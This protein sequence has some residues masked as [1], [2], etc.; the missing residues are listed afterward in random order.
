MLVECENCG[1]LVKKSPSHVKTLKHIFCGKKCRT[2]YRFLNKKNSKFFENINTEEKAYWLGF[3][4][5]DGWMCNRDP[6]FGVGL[7]SVDKIHLMKFA[8]L[9]DAKIIENTR[10]VHGKIYYRVQ[11]QV[12]NPFLYEQLLSKGV[13]PNKSLI[14]RLDVF[15][16][17]PKYLSSHFVRGWFDGDGSIY[18]NKVKCANTF[19]ICGT[20]GNLRKIQS[21]IL[22][23]VENLRVTKIK[24][25]KG[26]FALE[27]GGSHQAIAI[28]NW[29]YNDATVFLSRKKEKFNKVVR[30][31]GK[32]TSDYRGVHWN[33]ENEKWI[34]QITYNKK[35]HYLGSF[36][37]EEM[38][39]LAYT[40]ALINV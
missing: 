3:I 35:V 31:I 2:E 13:V 16:Y 25:T 20:K 11:I 10:V 32:K 26:I 19:S 33:K 22:N 18:I 21:M 9:F 29:L 1:E 8:R 37:E 27:W 17:V 38:A 34:A 14:N 23:G 5:A 15:K 4:C 30:K 36:R 24:S 39:A 12:Y 28:R 6:S 7:S 40:K